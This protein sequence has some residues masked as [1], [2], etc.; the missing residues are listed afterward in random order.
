M[1][2]A[3][4]YFPSRY[5]A[6]RYWPKVGADAA[7]ARN[8][9]SWPTLHGPDSTFRKLAGVDDTIRDLSGGE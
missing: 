5:F 3:D 8:A 6:P 9:T 7:T 2:G 4:R 1:V